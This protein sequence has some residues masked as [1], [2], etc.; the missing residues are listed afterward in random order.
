MRVAF[1]ANPIPDYLQDLVFHGLATLLGPANVVEYPPLERYHSRA[2]EG[3]KYPQLWFDFP[4]PPR[5]SF[6]ETV[7]AADVVVVGSLRPEVR[8]YVEELLT[9]R[10]RPPI[11]HLDGE[12]DFYVR[13]ISTLVDLYCKREILLGGLTSAGR[14]RLAR[15][16]R[17][18]RVRDGAARPLHE[19]IAIAR[20]TTPGLV[21]LPLGWIGPTFDREPL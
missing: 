3:T 18:L 9:L 20:T 4:E 6:R 8:T 1:L 10:P 13:R 14:L 2:P 16:R 15:L 19:R 7:A 11:V 5:T 21:S 12:D 17:R